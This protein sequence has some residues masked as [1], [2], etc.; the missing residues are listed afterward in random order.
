LG[1]LL[2]FGEGQANTPLVFVSIVMLTLVG[3]IA[4]LAV[5]LV[6]RRVL[7]YLPKRAVGGEL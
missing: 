7:H 2:A 3:G 6:E 4:Y 5:I 1:Y